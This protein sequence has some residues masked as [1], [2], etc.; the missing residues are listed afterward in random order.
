MLDVD[1]DGCEYVLQMGFRPAPVAAAAHAVSVGELVDGALDTGADRVSGLPL[2]CLL[3]CAGADL[4]VSE[5]SRG[6]PALRGSLG[7][8]QRGGPGTAGTGFW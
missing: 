3:L 8:V 2:G 5:F 1:G 6:K 7:L 4:Q